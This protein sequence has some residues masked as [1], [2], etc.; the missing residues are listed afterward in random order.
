MASWVPRA[1]NR[2]T[3]DGPSPR[4]VDP[5]R[6]PLLQ[7]GA[8]CGVELVDAER[9]LEPGGDPA[10]TTDDE[11]PRLGF[12]VERVELGSQA[13]LE[14]VVAVDLLVDEGHA[15]A[16]PGFELRLDVDNRSAHA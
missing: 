7:S 8:N 3:A 16:V 2:A 12:Q 4:R 9:A 10:V 5:P 1:S 6:G 13:L 11:Q 14:H 15:S